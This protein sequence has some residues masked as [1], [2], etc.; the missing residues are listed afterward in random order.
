MSIEIGGQQAVKIDQIIDQS[1]V[2]N[3]HGREY[4]NAHAIG[5]NIS[6]QI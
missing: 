2:K 6:S 1:Q 4:V 5:H 3:E